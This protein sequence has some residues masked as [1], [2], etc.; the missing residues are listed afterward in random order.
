LQSGPGPQAVD[1][2]NVGQS[3]NDEEIPEAELL[4]R[5]HRPIPRPP[6]LPSPGNAEFDSS[7]NGVAQH[8]PKT[9]ITAARAGR[10]LAGSVCLHPGWRVLRRRPDC[11]LP[12]TRGRYRFGNWWC[13]CFRFVVFTVM[14]FPRFG[15]CQCLRWANGVSEYD[16]P[17]C[18]G[19]HFQI[20]SCML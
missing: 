8:G 17:P 13:T 16:S 20:L 18:S 4:G 11:G 7:E 1:S 10:H 5:G 14:Q 19:P 12:L 6:R 3:P 9:S 2:K 15:S